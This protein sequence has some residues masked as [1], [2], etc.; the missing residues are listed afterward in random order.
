ME[1]LGFKDSELRKPVYMPHLGGKRLHISS[2]E[3][4]EDFGMSSFQQ[5]GTNISAAF[6][7]MKGKSSHQDAQELL[8]SG[9]CLPCCAAACSVAGTAMIPGP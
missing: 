3:L 2:T 7:N 1:P 9:A 5:A 8:D 6:E 4:M